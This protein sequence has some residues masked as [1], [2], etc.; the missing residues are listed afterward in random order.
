MQNNQT[1]ESPVE[2]LDNLIKDIN[3]DDWLDKTAQTYV[4]YGVGLAKQT[5]EKEG[6]NFILKPEYNPDQLSFL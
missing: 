5:L 3:K 1:S 6:Y 2:I 4:V